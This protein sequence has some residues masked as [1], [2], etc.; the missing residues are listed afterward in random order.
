MTISPNIGE[1]WMVAREPLLPVVVVVEVDGG[2]V[3]GKLV[4]VVCGELVVVVVGRETRRWTL[5]A[6]PTLNDK[7]PSADLT[8]SNRLKKKI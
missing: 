4:I 5:F 7:V 8:A 3:L 2:V 1:E 6:N